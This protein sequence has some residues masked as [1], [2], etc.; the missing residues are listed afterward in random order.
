MNYST[1]QKNYRSER[2]EL[3]AQIAKRAE[4][5]QLLVV[6]NKIMYHA[7]FELALN[8]IIHLR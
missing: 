5:A 8:H 2:N 4:Q 3:L 1:T 7:Q 6:F